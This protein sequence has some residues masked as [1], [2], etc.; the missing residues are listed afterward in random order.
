MPVTP[1]RRQIS[2]SKFASHL[3]PS[4]LRRV[5]LLVDGGSRGTRLNLVLAG[6]TCKGL[7]EAETEPNG[8]P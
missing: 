1:E 4:H 7:Q 3:V 5:P 8:H 6:G 2:I